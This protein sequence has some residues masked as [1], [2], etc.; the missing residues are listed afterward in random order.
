VVIYTHILQYRKA[1]RAQEIKKET[2]GEPR[3]KKIFQRVILGT[4]VTGSP[5]PGLLYFANVSKRLMQ[6]PRAHVNYLSITQCRQ[7]ARKATETCDRRMRTS[8]SVLE[9]LMEAM[10]DFVNMAVNCSGSIK[11]G[12][13]LD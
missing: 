4:R 11:N 3:A 6:Q 7:L 9:L 13:L 8:T 5:D 10:G 1:G 2:L 12:E